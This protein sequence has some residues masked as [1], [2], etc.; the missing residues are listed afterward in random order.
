MLVSNILRR[1]LYV[2]ALPLLTLGLLAGCGN[3]NSSSSTTADVP[4]QVGDAL[5]DSTV[6]VV[7]S[8][9]Y[10]TDSLLARNYRAQMKRVMRRSPSQQPDQMQETHRKLIRGFARQHVLRGEAKARDIN[11]DTAQV[12]ARLAKLKQRYKSERQFRQQLAQSNM[13]V[14]SVRS[15]LADR[16]RQQ[17]L[18]QQMAENFEKPSAD[19]VQAYSKKNRRIRAQ[20]I[21]LKVGENA[22][23]T[24]VDSVREA[25][26]ALV[27]SAQMDNVDFAELA[28][29]HS[30]G[31]TARKGGDLGFFTRD[32]MVEEFADAAYALSD[33]GD[34]APEPVRTQFGFHVIRLTNAGKPMDTTKARKQMTQERR[35]QAVED[36]INAL[37]KDVTVR[38]NPKIASAGFY[39]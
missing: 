27:D 14:D 9:D 16:L 26:A 23:Q 17:N 5:S 1:S 2:L 34:V 29:R 15:L 33:S 37:L 7:V 32:Q 13:T 10:G 24:K 30:Q 31:P 35:K 25:A 39:E 8:S 28:R 3:G 12:S 38:V 11:A 21:L 4:Y 6:A 22:P 19:E 18:Q 36:Q 20:H